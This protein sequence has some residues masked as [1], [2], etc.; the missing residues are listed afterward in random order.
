[1]GSRKSTSRPVLSSFADGAR[2]WLEQRLAKWR[3]LSLA[4]KFLLGATCVLLPAMLLA[5]TWLTRL[6]K[7]GVIRNSTPTV[8]LYLENFVEPMLQ[9]LAHGDTLA[10]LERA[11]LDRLLLDSSVAQRVAS[12]KVWIGGGRVVYSS[13]A[14]ADGDVF[15]VGPKQRAAWQGAVAADLSSLVADENAGERALALPLMEIYI[16][17]RQRGSDR[18]IAVAEFYENASSLVH[19]LE[20]ARLQAWGLISVVTATLLAAL[21]GIVHQGSSTIDQQKSTLQAKVAEL[22]RL[23]DDNDRLRLRLRHASARASEHNEFFLRRLGA[24]LHD[25]PAQLLSAALLR[26]DDVALP[27]VKGF[28]GK[29]P[30]ELVRGILGDA[31]KE[32]RNLASGMSVPEIERLSLAETAR[33]AVNKHE[34]MTATRVELVVQPLPCTASA[35]VKLCAYRFI[36]EGLTNAWRHAEGKAQ[37]V[38][39]FSEASNL[40]ITVRDGGKG[41]EWGPGASKGRLGVRGLADRIESLGGTFEIDSIA[42]RGTTLMARIPMEGTENAAV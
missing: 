30:K 41:F 18:I 17:V 36:Q 35:S 22:T 6:I 16:P 12:F 3:E 13:R 38:E 33:L 8:A 42:G 25:G 2:R 14:N 32:L 39:L 34:A 4:H 21:Y 19:E 9:S 29:A 37:R 11:Q 10:V 27:P 24:D 28:E 23:L 40:V 20:L 1:M 7:D 26:F 5:G 15:P 31:L